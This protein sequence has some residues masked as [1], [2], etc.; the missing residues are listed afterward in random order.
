MSEDPLADETAPDD[1]QP[2]EGKVVP[3]PGPPPAPA[4][5]Q[6]GG[7]PGELRDIIPPHLRTW[8]GI[9]KAL[10]LALPPRPPSRPVPRGQVAQAARPHGRVGARRRRADRVRAAR[11]VVGQRAGVPPPRGRRDERPAEVAVPA[12]AR[13][14]GPPRPRLHPRRRGPR[15]GARRRG[16]DLVPAGAVAAYRPRGRPAAGVDRPAR[17]QADRDQRRRPVRRREADDGAHRPG[18][19]RARHRGDEQGAPRGPRARPSCR[20]TRRCATAPA[21]SPGSTCRTA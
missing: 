19:R 3:F 5:P 2:I 20:S 1:E 11:L 9:V 7:Q 8:Q 15:P 14:R 21:G 10:K 6:R 13:P 18:A 12:Q 16:G 4:K 17:G